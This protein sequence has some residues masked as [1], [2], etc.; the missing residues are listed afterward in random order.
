MHYLDTR[1]RLCLVAED[2]EVDAAGRFRGPIVG[3][4]RT[5]ACNKNLRPK[6]N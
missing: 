5:L 3:R 6:G 1:L 2:E 4:L